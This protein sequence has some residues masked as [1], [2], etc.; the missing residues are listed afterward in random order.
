M[1]GYLTWFAFGYSQTVGTL[2]TVSPVLQLP[3]GLVYLSAPLGLGLAALQYL[4][5]GIK[6]LSADEIYLA[7]DVPLRKED[8]VGDGI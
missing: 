5:A 4:L 8:P 7:Y 3:L 6:N 2:G 1:L